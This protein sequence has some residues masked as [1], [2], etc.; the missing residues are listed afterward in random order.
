MA[1]DL[2]L[3]LIAVAGAALIALIAGRPTGV[4]PASVF[5]LSDQPAT[6]SHAPLWA[7][8]T[9]TLAE[10]WRAAWDRA[11][12]ERYR[13]ML[14]PRAD[15]ARRAGGTA[16]ILLVD[17]ASTPETR[18]KLQ[19]FLSDLWHRADPEGFKIAV[20]IVL[21]GDSSTLRLPVDHPSLTRSWNTEY[22][23]P[24]SA[25]R[26]LCVA[27]VPAR[28]LPLEREPRARALLEQGLGPCAFYGAFGAPGPDIARW[29]RGQGLWF[30]AQPHWWE[31]GAAADPDVLGFLGQ[32]EGW[33]FFYAQFGFDG[34][35]CY[36]RIR[37]RCFRA[38][39]DSGA[40]ADSAP[41]TW[42]VAYWWD[43][44]PFLNSA[45]YLSDVA[46]ALGSERFMAFW[47]SD[48]PVDSAFH[49]ASD[50]TLA[51][52]TR[53]WATVTGPPLAVGT[54][55]FLPGMPASLLAMFLALGAT[56]WYAGRRQIG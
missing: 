53:H 1:R 37:D 18:A 11:K 23:F 41:T 26:A 39:Y 30:A 24:D 36:A 3:W 44:R 25:H 48:L 51:D 5:G 19:G 10:Q 4:P 42:R 7:T 43:G 40:V 45:S 46:H 15:S 33:R 22:L 8:R 16:P 27:V 17:G 31:R 14:E 38:V 55:A 12:L 52:W 35:A 28:N 21:V 49:L 6:D 29:L 54:A 34:V 47:G 20:G 9:A 32:P 13:E 2:K 50:T 56:V